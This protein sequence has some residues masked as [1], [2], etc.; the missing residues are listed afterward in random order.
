MCIRD[1]TE[2]ARLG[3]SIQ[4]SDTGLHPAQADHARH[5]DAGML[6]VPVVAAGIPTLMEAEEEMCIRDRCRSS[7]RRKERCRKQAS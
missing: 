5:L 4:F 2:G 3:R 1:S 6:G 7:L